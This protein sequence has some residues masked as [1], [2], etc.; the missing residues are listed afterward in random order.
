M[1]KSRKTVA[2]SASVEKNV[3]TAVE[4]LSTACKDSEK[5]VAARNRLRKQLASELRRLN[6][7]R[8]VLLRRKQKASQKAKAEPSR[9]NVQAARTAEKELVA[10]RKAL[11]KARAARAV[12]APE[13]AALKTVQ[14]QAK[15][16]QSAIEKADKV[17]N[18]PKKRRRATKK[19][20]TT[21]KK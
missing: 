18:K 16:Y 20:R 9:E 6:K 15:A 21:K 3:A 13:L 19:K 14:R 8:G 12:N 7:R 11:T 4:K 2:K 10:T 17:L 1:A 5:A